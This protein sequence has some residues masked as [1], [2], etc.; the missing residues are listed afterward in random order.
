MSITL[1]IIGMIFFFLLSYSLGFYIS[2]KTRLEETLRL[3]EEYK[4]FHFLQGIE[5]GRLRER[6][7]SGGMDNKC[8]L[9]R[10]Q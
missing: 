3:I 4:E 8:T 9:H 5:E 10:L 2:Y 6:E 7:E 1:H